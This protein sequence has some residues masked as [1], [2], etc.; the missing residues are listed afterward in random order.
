MGEGLPM[1]IRVAT[2]AVGAL[3]AVGAGAI[4]IGAYNSGSD[5]ATIGFDYAAGV[6]VAVLFLVTGLPAMVLA[7]NR[8]AP[9][10]ALAL[11]L[12]FPA[13]FALLF[14]AAVVAFESLK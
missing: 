4:A 9:K 11:A 7:W 5:H 12:G 6:I 3:D 8:R 1:N 10:V 2:L 13:V 14:L